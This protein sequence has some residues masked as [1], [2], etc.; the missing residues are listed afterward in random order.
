MAPLLKVEQLHIGFGPLEPLAGVDIA[1]DRG[2]I[3]GL[4]GE[5]GSGKSMT[6]MSVMGLLPLMGGRIKSGRV[7]F[8]GTDLTTISERDYRNLRGGRIALITQNPMTSLDPVMRVGRQIDQVAELHLKL[9]RKAAKEKTIG[10]MARMR[11]PSPEMTYDLFPHQ[12]SGGLRQRIVIAMALA[13]DPDLLI[14]DEPTTALDVTVQAQ[15]IALLSELVQ[16]KGLGLIL[17]THDMGVVAQT[18]DEV[19]VMYCGKVVEYGQVNAIFGAPRHPYTRALIGCI[20]QPGMAPR[21]LAGIPGMVPPAS[22]MPAGCRFNPRCPLAIDVCRSASPPSV[23]EAG[24]SVACF[25]AEG[26]SA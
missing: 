21:S 26:E 7:V 15:I 11:I 20:P 14:A 13:G 24:R 23:I 3:L 2:R 19:A 6:A 17:I 16:E 9:D 8:D 25:L 4:V 5:S 12:L 10:L 18:C 22:A 1:V